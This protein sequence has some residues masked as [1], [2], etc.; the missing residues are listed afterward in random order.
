MDSLHDVI[1]PP[2]GHR[3]TLIDYDVAVNYFVDYYFRCVGLLILILKYH[4][5]ILHH[6]LGLV[7]CYVGVLRSYEHHQRYHH[8][9]DVV[10]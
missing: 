1:F 7:I 3:T 8:P 4:H 2:S 10:V 5:G 9:E 6:R